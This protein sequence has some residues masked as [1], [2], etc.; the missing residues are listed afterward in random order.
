LPLEFGGQ[1]LALRLDVPRAGE[2]SVSVAEEIGFGPEEIEALRRD[3]VIAAER[4][5]ID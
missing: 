5:L 4:D 2:H 1:R 3:G